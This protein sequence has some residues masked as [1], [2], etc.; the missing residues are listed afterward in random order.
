MRVCDVSTILLIEAYGLKRIKHPPLEPWVVAAAWDALH[1]RPMSRKRE[2]RLRL[3]LGI[4]P[5]PVVVE[6][7]ACPDCGS[8]HHARCH[9]NGGEAVVLAPGETVRRPGQSRQR[10][11]YWRP[12]LPVT[13]TPQQREMVENYAATLAGRTDQ[14]GGV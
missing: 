10:T 4:E 5:L 11:R 6:V 2:E 13:L 9:G 14:K 3:A 1:G 8:V 12:C 7:S